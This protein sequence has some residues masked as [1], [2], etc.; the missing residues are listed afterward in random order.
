MIFGLGTLGCPTQTP[1]RRLGVSGGT[2]PFFK[3]VLLE[4]QRSVHLPN[5]LEDSL[6]FG[7][8]QW[9]RLRKQLL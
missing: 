9:A 1:V 8:C 2:A 6:K 7:P 3:L 5:R 4:P